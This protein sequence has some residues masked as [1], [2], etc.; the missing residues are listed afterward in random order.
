[1]SEQVSCRFSSFVLWA[2]YDP[3]QRLLEIDFKN[4]RGRKR[5]TYAYRD[6][7]PDR[8]DEFRY[9]RFRELYFVYQIR[10]RFKG[11]KIWSETATR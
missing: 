7:P 8:W 9:S 11:V 6:F 1:M 3:T 4:A 2:R 5:S 10:P